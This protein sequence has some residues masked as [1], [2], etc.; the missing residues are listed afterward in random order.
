MGIIR[1]LELKKNFDVFENAFFT[2]DFLTARNSLIISV[3]FQCHDTFNKI[4]RKGIFRYSKYINKKCIVKNI[5][6]EFTDICNDFGFLSNSLKISNIFIYLF[7]LTN[8]IPN[9]ES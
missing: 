1:I 6:I 7:F 8:L 9:W 4:K 5:A 2:G 3:F